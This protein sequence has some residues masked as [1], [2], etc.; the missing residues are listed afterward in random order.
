M[1]KVEFEVRDSAAE[2]GLPAQILAL[3]QHLGVEEVSITAIDP[4]RTVI[5]DVPNIARA[6]A[7]MIEGC[8]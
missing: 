8:G 3:V 4:I 6:V 1:W 7:S 5:D 2:L